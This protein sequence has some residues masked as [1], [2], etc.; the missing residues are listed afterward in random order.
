MM[1]KQ[2][3]EGIYQGI[4]G[5]EFVDLIKGFL[6][7]GGLPDKYI[8]ILVTPSTMRLWNIAFTHKSANHRNNYEYIEILGDS[9]LNAS[10]VTYMNDR[11][12]HIRTPAGVQVLGRLKINYVSQQSFYMIAENLG[13]WPYITANVEAR[14]RRMKSFLE[15]CLEAVFGLI[16]LLLNTRVKKNVGFALVPDIVKNLYSDI[17]ISLDYYKLYDSKTI[18]KQIFDKRKEL[19]T[20]KYINRTQND[21]NSDFTRSIVQ[22]VRIVSPQE[23]YIIGE[24]SGPLKALAEQRTAKAALDHLSSQNINPEIPEGFMVND[25]IA[26]KR[27]EIESEH[28]EIYQGIRGDKF[29]KLIYKF[30]KRGKLKDEW[31]QQ[32]LSPDAMKVWDIAFTHQSADQK[33]NYEY[34]RFIGNTIAKSLLVWYFDEK[35]PQIQCPAGVPIMARLKIVHDPKKTFIYLAKNLDIWPFITTAVDVRSKNIDLILSKC[36]ESMIGATSILLDEKI[37]TNIGLAIVPNIIKSMY[38]EM[39]DISLDYYDLFDS[40]T[41]LKQIFD[42]RKDIGRLEYND[43]TIRE[44]QEGTEII[45]SSVNLFILHNNGYKQPIAHAKGSTKADAEQSVSKICLS[46]LSSSMGIEPE[47]SKDYLTFCT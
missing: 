16:T 35:F 18:L 20:L 4:R 41:I 22:I 30:L 15:D 1:Q 5:Q 39:V 17:D 6:K 29:V 11:F 12:P 46:Y 37:R 2:Q 42:K 47:I 27:V 14:K 40:K 13:F 28:I 21:Y 8:Q 24:S 36:L 34:M 38:D 44:D 33:N 9:I 23:K 31:I 25:T 10:I 43:E 45:Y 26:E 32:L 7:K 3:H 19:G